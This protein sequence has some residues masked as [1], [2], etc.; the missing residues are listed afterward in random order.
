M[1]LGKGNFSSVF[2]SLYSDSIEVDHSDNSKEIEIKVDLVS[3]LF[4]SRYNCLFSVVNN[5]GIFYSNR[6]KKLA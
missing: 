6:S 5:P 2:I 1:N 3:T 4:A